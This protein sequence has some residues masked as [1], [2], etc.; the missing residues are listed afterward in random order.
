MFMTTDCGIFLIKDMT[1]WE[2]SA[3]LIPPF[4]LSHPTPARQNRKCLRPNFLADFGV[5]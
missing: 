1:F 4:E 3:V 5:Y 2:F